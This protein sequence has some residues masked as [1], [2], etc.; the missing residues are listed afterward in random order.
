MFWN[1]IKIKI[2]ISW[3]CVFEIIQ[4]YMRLMQIMCI[5]FIY[6]LFRDAPSKLFKLPWN[7]Y[8]ILYLTVYENTSPL[9]YHRL[10]MYITYEE[11]SNLILIF[12]KTRR[13]FLL[14]Y[15]VQWQSKILR[16]RWKITF[17][18]LTISLVQFIS[19][20]YGPEV[21]S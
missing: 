10:H 8:T 16:F 14:M 7:I 13:L 9:K 2:N 1:K 15:L 6:A 20:S 12:R 5:Y 21:A 19:L 4:N 17:N 3:Q 11:S 18:I